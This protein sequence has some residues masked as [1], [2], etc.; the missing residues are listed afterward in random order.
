MHMYFFAM[1]AATACWCDW[2]PLVAFAAVTVFH[3][4]IL[5]YMNVAAV[6]PSDQPDIWRVALHS[7]IVFVQTAIL[8]VV[9]IQA[10]RLFAR[11]AEALESAQSAEARAEALL[12]ER[13]I[14]AKSDE[15]R[16]KSL[17]GLLDMFGAE[18]SQL[19]SA[20]RS[21]ST[22]L[23]S[24]ST[25]LA[26]LTSDA[27][28]SAA[29]AARRAENASFDVEAVAGATSEIATSTDEMSRQIAATSQLIGSARSSALK[30]SQ[31]IEMLAG[32]ARSIAEVVDIIRGIA[33]Q[34]NLLALNA[35]IE[36][37][38]AGEAGR[39]FS[40]VATEVK[41]LADQS[42]R[43]TEDVTRRIDAVSREICAAVDAIDS[44]S[45]RFNEMSTLGEAVAAAA[46]QQ[47][48]ATREISRSASSVATGTRAV[49]EI[50]RGS[51]GVAQQTSVAADRIRTDAADVLRATTE[52]EQRIRGFIRDVA[53]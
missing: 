30:T 43:A 21:R 19:L 51:E 37:A 38:R 31:A 48:A 34:T 26:R 23:D 11:N 7:A 9:C 1:L 32:E 36:A 14:S 35:T 5:N 16:R 22:D 15:K 33:D 2:R 25:D 13:T 17:E 45:S 40:V 49:S 46:E 53:A 6:F 50:S 10:E 29:E 20:L 18:V 28:T 12:G 41:S 47:Q 4:L 39:G 24:R 27:S 42:S 8:A 52:L 44:F 3:H